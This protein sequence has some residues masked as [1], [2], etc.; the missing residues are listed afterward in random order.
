MHELHRSLVMWILSTMVAMFLGMFGRIVGIS[1]SM[2][3]TTERMVQTIVR[4]TQDAQVAP[5]R[6]APAP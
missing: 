1:S 4:G 5:P 6:P 3:E 2:L